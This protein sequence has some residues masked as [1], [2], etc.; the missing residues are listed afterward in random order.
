[1]RVAAIIPALDEEGAIGGV[2]RA[3]RQ[4]AVEGDF[5]LEIVVVDNGS[6]DRTAE[7][8][9]ASGAH[10]VREPERG[11]GAACLA[12]I[13]A[14]VPA[15][16]E[17]VLF[18]DGDGSSDVDET[19]RL[20]APIRDG[21]AELVIGSRVRH[22]DA[23]ALTVPQRFGNV[24]ATGL[25]NRLHGSRYTD[26]GPFRALRWTTLEELDMQDRDYGWT[27]EMQLKAARL[28]VATAEVDVQHHARIAGR[29]KVAGTVRG[30]IGAGTKILWT[31]GR[32][33]LP[34]RS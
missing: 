26:L 14:L 7:R 10:V 15:P 16:P 25:L 1:M 5:D 28:G 12:G 8:A 2:V 3:L 6:R 34:P 13:S 29:S 27:V 21:S 32:L 23:G 22:A 11:Y 31:I 17:V 30:V 9:R 24:L 33:S 20:L 18:V 19:A 4:A